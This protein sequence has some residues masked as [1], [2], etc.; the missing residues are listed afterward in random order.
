MFPR[1]LLT[2]VLMLLAGA[3]GFSLSLLHWNVAGNGT[4]KTVGVPITPG[5]NKLFRL[6][7]P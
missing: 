5:T 1:F 4:T 7:V 6:R 3:R 2:L